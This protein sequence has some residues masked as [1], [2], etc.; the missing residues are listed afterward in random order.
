MALRIRMRQQGRN[1]C[2]FY[3]IVV[4]DSRSPRDGKYLEVVGWYNPIAQELE[5][6]LSLKADRI[7]HWIGLGAQLTDNVGALI[8]RGAPHLRRQQSEKI[9]AD[10]AKAAAK[11]RASK[12]AA[13]K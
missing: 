4:T 3:R 6:T 1:N 9:V 2:A 8:A 5:K 7:Q 10:R 12:Q 13:V 11:R